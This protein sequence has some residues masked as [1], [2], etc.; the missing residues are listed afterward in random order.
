[1]ECT[2]APGAAA[3]FSKPT[4]ADACAPVPDPGPPPS[5]LDRGRSA[6]R[7]RMA[8]RA[9]VRAVWRAARV[10]RRV[11]RIPRRRLGQGARASVV[12]AAASPPSPPR[13]LSPPPRRRRQAFLQPP[14]PRT[15]PPPPTL[16]TPRGPPRGEASPR[17]RATRAFFASRRSDPAPRGRLRRGVDQR[18]WREE[19]TK[20][21]GIAARE[22][23]QEGGVR[24]EFVSAG[25][26]G[27]PHRRRSRRRRT[28]ARP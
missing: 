4:A 6:A 27:A 7:S 15:P 5:F 22:F 8:A 11:L 9:S 20:R 28:A 1:M 16:R 3:N 21:G 24:R 10:P 17:R 25:T 2:N 13:R 19:R 23:T 18:R 12:P 26:A 14:P